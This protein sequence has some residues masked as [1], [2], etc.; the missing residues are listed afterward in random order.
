MFK[1][2]V[3]AAAGV[4]AVR[5]AVQNKCDG[6]TDQN[7]E[8]KILCVHNNKCY[9]KANYVRK[10]EMPIPEGSLVQSSDGNPF[11]DVDDDEDDWIEAKRGDDDDDEEGSFV[12]FYNAGIGGCKSHII[13]LMKA[14][15]CNNQATCNPYLNKC[16]AAKNSES[17]FVQ[18]A[19]STG[20]CRDSCLSG[21]AGKECR[22]NCAKGI[23]NGR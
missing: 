1:F 10:C 21:R 23:L 8:P 14:G 20:S 2:A 7:D 16:I 22:R 4:E 3:V 5:V 17:A 12:Q 15:I 6:K 9:A 19:A 11:F 13:S 18:P